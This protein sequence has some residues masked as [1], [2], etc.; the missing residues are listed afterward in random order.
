MAV[1]HVTPLA[2]PSSFEDDVVAEIIRTFGAR[3]GCF[4]RKSILTED[5][6]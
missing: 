6:R 5:E 4:C 3:K 1:I 2:L